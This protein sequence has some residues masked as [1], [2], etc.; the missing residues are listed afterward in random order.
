MA[1]LKEHY[2]GLH[3]LYEAAEMLFDVAVDGRTIASVAAAAPARQVI[4]Y[5]GGHSMWLGFG[6]PFAF[7][8]V[9]S[10]LVARHHSKRKASA[11]K[12]TQVLHK[13]RRS[14]KRPPTHRQ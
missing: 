4:K 11:G 9:T 14:V 3:S 8:S 13:R 12:Q 5:V 7:V 2:M 6:I 1:D 10:V